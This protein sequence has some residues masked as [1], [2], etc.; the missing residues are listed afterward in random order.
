MTS[1]AQLITGELS[2]LSPLALGLG[3]AWVLV[4]VC[5]PIIRWVLGAGAERIGISLGVIFQAALVGALLFGALPPERAARAVIGIP[6]FGWAIEFVGSRTG[7]PF[8]EYHYTTVLQPQIRRVPLIIPLAWLMMIPP[9]WAVGTLLSGGHGV[10]VPALFAGV[11]FMA[12]DLFLDPQMVGWGFWRWPG[13]GAYLGIPLSNFAGWFAAGA[14]VSL[15]FYTAQIPVV[16]LLL[17]YVVT[18]ILQTIGQ[19]AFW[20]LIVSGIVGSLAMGVLI[21]LSL[22]RLV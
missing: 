3:A 1:L 13:G 22:L 20:R 7:I 2:R 6:L 17:V 16:A 10:V 5:V 21:V 18:W 4:M 12:W 9:S 11:A 19:L 14:V 15:L 8:G